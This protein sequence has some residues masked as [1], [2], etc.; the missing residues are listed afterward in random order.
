[1]K[2]FIIIG[3]VILFSMT[4][5]AQDK[6]R[7]LMD[8]T[9]GTE[10]KTAYKVGTYNPEI[11]DSLLVAGKG[12]IKHFAGSLDYPQHYEVYVKLENKEALLAI[13]ARL[14]AVYL[15]RKRRQ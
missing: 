15:T 1:M 11:F 13:I 2:Q 12:I 8:E 9:V 3:F 10:T 6:N 14:D 4:V 5:T 7:L